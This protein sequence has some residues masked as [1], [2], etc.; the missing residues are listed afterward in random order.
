MITA[1]DPWVYMRK[2]QEVYVIKDPKVPDACLGANYIGDQSGKWSIS[3][4][5]YIKEAIRQIEE[6]LGITIRE[7]KTPIRTNDHPEEDDSPVLNNEMHTEY[8][9]LM[10]MLQWLVSL[11]RVDICFAVS[12]LSRFCSCPREGHMSRAFRI[13]GYLKKYPN[14]SLGISYEKFFDVGES[15]DYEAID[16]LEQ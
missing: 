16:F 12:S 13:W 15:I 6:R 7:E 5:K 8:Q 9:S 1:K 10:G 14:R 3:A 11:H 4:R 2:L